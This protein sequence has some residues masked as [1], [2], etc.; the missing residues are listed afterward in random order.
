MMRPPMSPAATGLLRSLIARAGIERDKILLTHFESTDWHSLT[1]SGERHEISLR[2]VGDDAGSAAERLLSNIA[3]AE[4]RIP[5]SIVAD[6]GLDERAE[7]TDG[8]VSLRL[9]A[10]TILE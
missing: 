5:G 10:L 9:E 2:L 1:F 8:S 4:W 6:I 3:E 7:S